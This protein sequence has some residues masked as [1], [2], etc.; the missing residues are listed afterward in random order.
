MRWPDREPYEGA[1]HELFP[2]WKEF[3][4]NPP[5]ED[6]PEVAEPAPVD[7]FL[8]RMRRDHPYPKIRIR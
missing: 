7:E 2:S 3:W 8:T 4:E 5:T 1:Y 6:E